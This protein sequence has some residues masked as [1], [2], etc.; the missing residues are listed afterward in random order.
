MG[1]SMWHFVQTNGDAAVHD[2]ALAGMDDSAVVVIDRLGNLLGLSPASTGAQ[3]DGLTSAGCHIE[4]T[5][6]ARTS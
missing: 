3:N 5:G 4:A 1:T 2:C 6:C